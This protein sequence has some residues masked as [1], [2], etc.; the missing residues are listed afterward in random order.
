[1]NALVETFIE[2]TPVVRWAWIAAGGFLIE[3]AF[4]G[5]RGQSFR[6]KLLNIGSGFLVCVS[7]F[8]LRPLTMM[9]GYF[10][11]RRFGSGLITLNIFHED[12]ILAQIGC[13]LLYILV[14]DFFY[15]FLHRCQHKVGFLWDIHAIHHS[16]T[17]FNTTTY[18]RQHWLNSPANDLFVTIPMTLLFDLPPVT[19]FDIS[20]V[21]SVWLFFSHMNVRL[22]LGCLSWVV[23][24][25]QLH[26]LHHSCQREHIDTNFAQHFPIW[27]VLF[28]TYLHPKKDEFPATG[29]ASGERV[30]TLDTLFFSPFQKWHRKI[31]VRLSESGGKPEQEVG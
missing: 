11:A 9:F 12:T 31:V 4:S 29:L 8:V 16:D 27:D 28:G 15:Y 10:L 7:V 24:G 20:L 17:A 6:G 13:L 2:Q 21:L 25:P 1:V 5:N 26:R 18:L 14:K 19:M 3:M 30:D 23:T 22:Q